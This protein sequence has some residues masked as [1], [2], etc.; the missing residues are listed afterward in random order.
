MKVLRFFRANR[1]HYLT[2]TR[3]MKLTP[4]Q[5][6]KLNG[7][8]DPKY[9]KSRDQGGATLDYVDGHYVTTMLNAVFGN[10]GWSLD[11]KDLR[12]VSDRQEDRTSRDGSKYTAQNTAYLC[13]ATLH[14]YRDDGDDG[15]YFATED[16]GAGTQVDKDPGKAHEGAA[17][18]AVTDAMKRCAKQLGNAMGLA[19]YDK[20]QAGVGTDN[21]PVIEHGARKGTPLSKFSPDKLEAYKAKYVAEFSEQHSADVD[22]HIAGRY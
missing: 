17:K 7:K 13:Q 22:M 15:Y 4:E 9:V 11:I 18:E 8:L 21:E 1:K 2:S 5:L 19:L 16:V 20:E 10:C 6:A 3:K 14:V 12:C